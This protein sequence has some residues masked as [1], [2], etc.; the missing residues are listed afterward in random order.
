MDQDVF[1]YSWETEIFKSGPPV[2]PRFCSLFYEIHIQHLPQIL[3]IKIEDKK[4]DI[5]HYVNL[6]RFSFLNY[7][8]DIIREHNYKKLAFGII[9]LPLGSR[10]SLSKI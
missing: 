6:I 8:S 1:L 10:P 7:F 2:D 9:C 5:F 4:S 3:E